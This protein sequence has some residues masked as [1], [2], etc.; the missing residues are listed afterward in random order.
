MFYYLSEN[1]TEGTNAGNKARNDVERIL[2]TRNSV[3]IS[4][5]TLGKEL[6]HGN[7]LL[8]FMKNQLYWNK[9]KRIP[10]N[11]N[12]FVQYPLQ[13]QFKGQEKKITYNYLFNKLVKR[14]KVIVLVHDLTDLRGDDKK[15]S[16]DD[17]KKADYIICHN[18]SME[19][20]LIQKG[21]DANKLI[22]LEIFDYLISKEN[23]F[24]HYNDEATICF[25]G[26]L[27]KSKFI[28][29][30]PQEVKELGINLYGV[31]YSRKEKGIK[32]WG[33]FGSEEI[34]SIIKGK[35]G[36]IWD[37]EDYKSCVGLTGNYLK[38]NNPHKLSMY[39]VSN[40]PVIIW[41]QAAEAQFVKNNNIGI[42]INSLEE[43]PSVVNTLSKEDYEI[44]RENVKKIKEKLEKGQ[45]LRTALDSAKI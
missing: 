13:A 3:A 4:A 11:A 7:R 40:M 45:Y 22:N 35:F 37:G 18:S 2:E 32:Y 31:G 15:S 9:I 19:K 29:N 27:N 36:L 25:A 12:F 8:F 33:S 44:M 39:L 24:D 30:L 10:K 6:P 28:Y 38:Y 43:L 26:N 1:N 23:I 14:F 34:S 5:P 41:S 16:T 42:L 20:Y 21:I 17:L